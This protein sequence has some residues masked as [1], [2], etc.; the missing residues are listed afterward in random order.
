MSDDVDPVSAAQRRARFRLV[1]DEDAAEPATRRPEPP[2]AVL[3]GPAVRDSADTADAAADLGFAER[4]GDPVRADRVHD[5]AD[6]AAD[7]RA[8]EDDQP[9]RE[10]AW[11]TEWRASGEPV[12]WLTGMPL[13]AFTALITGVAVW[14]LTAGLAD[15]LVLVVALNLLVAGGLAPAMW[16]CRDLPVLRWFAGGAAVGIVAGWVAVVLMLPLG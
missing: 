10:W 15:R 3:V 14:V 13:A 11:V 4:A 12:P 7:D 5:I 2:A 6:G 9:A 1:T 16:L 8:G